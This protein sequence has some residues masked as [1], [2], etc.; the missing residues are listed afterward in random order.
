[1]GRYTWGCAAWIVIMKLAC[2][3]KGV[4]ASMNCI[5]VG[6]PDEQSKE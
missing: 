4:K 1:M 2:H 3:D 5:R 6:N